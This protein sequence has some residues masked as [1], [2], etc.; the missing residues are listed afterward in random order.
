MFNWIRHQGKFTP[1]QGQMSAFA[2]KSAV[3]N[4]KT[5]AAAAASAARKAAR[6]AERETIHRFPSVEHLS[7]AEC[8]RL[9]QLPLTVRWMPPSAQKVLLA[10]P[11]NVTP[12]EACAKHPVLIERLLTKWR[13]P[14][15]F[16][17][18]LEAATIDDRSAREGFSFP[19]MN[20]LG[21]LGDYYDRFVFPKKNGAWANVDPY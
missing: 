10:L 21:L 6:K 9:K 16:R 7:A 11:D 1:A 20:E 5:G 18:A 13:D 14:I 15:A 17:A 3:A 2:G 8:E 4:P 19:V 12:R